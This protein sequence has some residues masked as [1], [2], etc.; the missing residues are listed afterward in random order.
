[1]DLAGY[2]D[3]ERSTLTRSLN[4]SCKKDLFRTAG[5]SHEKLPACPDS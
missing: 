4:P 3:L 5:M 1:M 2:L